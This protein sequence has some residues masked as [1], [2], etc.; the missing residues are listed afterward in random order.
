V[1]SNTES[2]KAERIEYAAMML[3]EYLDGGPKPYDEV[4]EYCA[5]RGITKI[6]LKA[7]RKEL[8]VKTINTGNTWLRCVPDPEDEGDA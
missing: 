8:N 2:T 7:A 6:E 3:A 1:S 4:K 5:K